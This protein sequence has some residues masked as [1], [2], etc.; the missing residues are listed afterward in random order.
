MKFAFAMPYIDFLELEIIIIDVVLQI[1]INQ[2]FSYFRISIQLGHSTESP[3]YL[4]PA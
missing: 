3:F 2:Y 1:I 4:N